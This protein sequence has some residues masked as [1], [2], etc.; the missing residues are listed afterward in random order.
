MKK[1]KIIPFSLLFITLTFLELFCI[2][3]YS[4]VFYFPLAVGTTLL[5]SAYLLLTEIMSV[6]SSFIKDRDE[7]AKETKPDETHTADR[8]EAAKLAK[9]TYVLEKRILNLL[10]ERILMPEE[11]I[12]NLSSLQSEIIRAI[13]AAIKYGVK[14]TNN[15]TDILSDN[16]TTESGL[17]QIIEKIDALIFELKNNQ[18]TMGA[19]KEQLQTVTD[20]VEQ[21]SHNTVAFS[22]PSG[23]NNVIMPE[24]ESVS[25]DIVP[26]YADSIADESNSI[27]EENSENVVAAADDELTEMPEFVDTLTAAEPVE[28]SAEEPASEKTTEPV[29]DD[30]NKK[31]NPEDIAA[32]FAAA[33]PSDEPAKEAAAEKP[34]SPASDDPNNKMNPED[35]AALFAAAVP[36]DEPAKEAASEK[37]VSSASDDPNKKMN[38]ED[39]A[40]LFAAAVPSDEPAKEAVAEKTVSPVSDDPNK[41]MNPEDIAALFAAAVPSDEPAKEAVAEKTVSPVSDDPNKKM[42]PEDIAALFA[43]AVP[44]DEPAKEGAAEKPVSPA[45]DDPN[46]KMNP[47]DIA[48]LFAAANLELEPEPSSPA[49]K[50]A[51]EALSKPTPV[52][53]D[54]NKKMSPEDIAALF[55]S[56]GQ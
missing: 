51:I 22:Q 21:A 37:T 38:P 42:N 6:I 13:K 15:I 2:V 52:S 16:S 32:L 25:K 5:G 41:K 18:S 53:D 47:E 34:V 48:A 7:K 30:P 10:E 49:P 12:E 27:I 43:A 46:K 31:M 33:V 45:S 39:I 20:M 24:N 29:S 9:A 55:A 56:A 50:T 26:E 1:N 19:I 23:S 36:S 44:S 40:A 8:E 11:N 17:A 35:I 28:V 4:D 3:K 14:N 54:P